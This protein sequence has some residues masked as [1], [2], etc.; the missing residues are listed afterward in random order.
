MNDGGHSEK[1]NNKNKQ[2]LRVQTIILTS[3]SDS[4]W[5]L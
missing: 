4:T 2:E 5:S 1:I 3:L